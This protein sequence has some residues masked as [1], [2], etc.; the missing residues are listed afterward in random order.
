[1]KLDEGFALWTTGTN[2]QGGQKIEAGLPNIVGHT[3]R[4]AMS[5]IWNANDSNFELGF[6]GAFYVISRDKYGSVGAGDTLWSLGFDASRSN[7]IYGNSNTVQP[8]AIKIFAWER[9]ET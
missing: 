9:I 5:T 8:P 4:N 3:Q 1:M 7:S 2:G 6:D